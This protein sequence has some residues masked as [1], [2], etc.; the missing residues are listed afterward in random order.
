MT[1]LKGYSRGGTR[2]AFGVLA[3]NASGPVGLC[4]EL[5]L[6]SDSFVIDQ[7]PLIAASM[8][9]PAQVFVFPNQ[10][11]QIPLTIVSHRKEPS[12]DEEKYIWLVT[13]FVNCH[14]T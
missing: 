9:L 3:R 8:V 10:I 12:Q 7:N 14:T 2:A 5:V 1:R 13:P 6:V 4:T 11:L